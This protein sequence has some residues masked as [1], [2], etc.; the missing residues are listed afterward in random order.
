[1]SDNST[2]NQVTSAHWRT[3]LREIENAKLDVT[4]FLRS[5]GLKQSDLDQPNEIRS[6]VFARL[7]ERAIHQ[8]E[9]ESI[10]LIG[11][12]PVPPGTF[13]MM[14]LCVIHLQNLEA[15][16]SRAGEFHDVCMSSQT[17]PEI[18]NH[19]GLSC[20]AIATTKHEKRKIEQ[21]LMREKPASIRSTLFMW[22]RLLSWFAGF[23][24]PLQKVVFHF[25]EPSSGDRWSDLFQC[26]V[27]FNGVRT[28]LC[29]EADVLK[30]PNVQSEQS[31]SVFLQSVPY[32][33][34]SPS[35]T[36][37]RLSERVLALFG[38]N[39]SRQ[40]PGA[41]AVGQSLGLSVSTLRRQ[42]KEEGTS[43]QSL[44]DEHR[45]EAAV[46]Y[47]D[48]RSLSFSDIAER[49]GFDEPSAFFRAFKRWTGQT[50]SE[51]RN[52]L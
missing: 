49:L 10:G 42:L 28:M 18:Q 36:D 9:D 29:F 21:L 46:K 26:P 27:Q 19:E 5:E 38:G 31:L 12:I 1:M 11:S 35:F 30:L 52:N 40:L 24:L 23:S 44:K 41:E 13:R 8:L 32:K 47:L 7:Y 16:V 25:N 50:P 6:D 3:L 14:C 33:L 34:I 22:H 43:F 51:Y 2:G 20:V 15:V 4:D 37:H 45:R 17:K 48:D 39:L